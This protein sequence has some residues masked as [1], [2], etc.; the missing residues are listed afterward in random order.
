MSVFDTII[1]WLGYAVLIICGVAIGYWLR[2][3]G[4]IMGRYKEIDGE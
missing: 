4:E 1:R 3:T 2:W